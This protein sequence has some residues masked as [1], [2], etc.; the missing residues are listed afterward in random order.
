MV[1]VSGG[2]HCGNLHAELVLTRTPATYSPR[3]CDCDFCRKHG[4]AYVSDPAGSLRLQVRDAQQLGRYRQGSGAAELLLCRNCG[5][6]IGAL[7]TAE[8]RHYAAFNARA[9]HTSTRFGADQQV[10]PKELAAADKVRRWQDLWCRDVR[11]DI[12]AR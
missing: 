9:A 1:T 5:V 8:G 7:F 6:L 2:C 10:S 12:D 4:A 3:A 11:L